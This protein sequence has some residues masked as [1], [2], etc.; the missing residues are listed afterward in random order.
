MLASI[1]CL[2]FLP[3]VVHPQGPKSSHFDPW[4]PKKSPNSISKSSKFVM[5]NASA[6]RLPQRTLSKLNFSIF[7]SIFEA[8]GASQNWA[9]IA[10]I[11]KKKLKIRRWKKHAVQHYFFTIFLRFNLPKRP[12]N[13]AFFQYFLKTSI[14]RK[15]LR[16]T[17]CAHKNQGSDFKKTKKINK[18]S[19]PKRIREKHRKKP[20]KNRFWPPFWL[21][22][23]SQNGSK[24]DPERLQNE[25][26]FATLCKLPASRRKST[27]LSVC[28]ASKWL[29]IW[30]GLLD[31]LLVALG[32]KVSP[33][34][35][36]AFHQSWNS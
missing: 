24:S 1:L 12:P 9:K 34:T 5:Q 33:P 6:A 32:I 11:R 15:S 23:P 25:A 28:K 36:N 19:K 21:P 3:H 29:G 2:R 26:C 10:K 18:K 27:G 13:R 17:G 30:L 35:W 8:P 22:K 20:R 7:L 16:N 31:L 4:R 14:L